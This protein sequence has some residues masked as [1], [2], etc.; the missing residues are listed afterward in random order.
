MVKLLAEERM[1]K[2]KIAE[3][4]RLEYERLNKA[5][6]PLQELLNRLIP[7]ED[8]NYDSNF[9]KELNDKIFGFEPLE[10]D[11]GYN[12]QNQHNSTDMAGEN[13]GNN[14]PDA[15]PD[16]LPVSSKKPSNENI[17]LG[18]S[19]H[20]IRMLDLDKVNMQKYQEDNLVEENEI[21]QRL[22]ELESMEIIDKIK[23]ENLETASLAKTKEVLDQ[24]M[25]AM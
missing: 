13:L 4:E 14:N 8:I 3:E 10:V 16:F 22:K 7:V 18:N 15:I 24:V 25:H 11:L 23:G 1:L 17:N 5:K 2:A 6:D 9:E 20:T 19:M 21:N 12:H